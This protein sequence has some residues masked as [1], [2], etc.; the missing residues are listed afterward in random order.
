[1][2]ELAT[3]PIIEIRIAEVYSW[4]IFKGSETYVR[5]SDSSNDRYMMQGC[6]V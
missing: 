1:M 4:Q 6:R 3:A 2:F 5:I